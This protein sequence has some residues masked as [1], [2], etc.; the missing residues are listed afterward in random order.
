MENNKVKGRPPRNPL[1]K[2]EETKVEEVEN[3]PEVQ[4]E[5]NVELETN[6]EM[7]EETKVEQTKET[8]KEVVKNNDHLQ[9]L[10]GNEQTVTYNHKNISF[11]C[12]L[13]FLFVNRD[14]K[15]G[16]Y[17]HIEELLKDA[18]NYEVKPE[19]QNVFHCLIVQQD[20]DGAGR[21]TFQPFVQKFNEVDFLQLKQN[22]LGIEFVVI[23]RPSTK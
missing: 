16:L 22:R 8:K 18:F 10:K 21:R 11:E 7:Q 19:E 20:F 1:A 9:N 15:Q 6:N 2:Q 13:G 3:Q 12:S 5:I 4:T 14:I 17:P 23:Y